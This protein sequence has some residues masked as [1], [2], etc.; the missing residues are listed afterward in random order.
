MAYILTLAIPTYN[1]ADVLDKTL[2]RIVSDPACDERVEIIVSD[3]C[4]QDSTRDVVAKYPCVKYFCNTENIIDANFTKILENSTGHYLKLVN[5]TV[6]FNPGKIEEMIDIISATNSM[7]YNLLFYQNCFVNTDKIVMV[8]NKEELLKSVS[9]YTTWSANFGI[10]KKDFDAFEDKNR[11]VETRF[12]QLDW[13]YRLVSNGKRSKI[14]FDDFFTIA[15]LKVKGGYNFYKVFVDNY[16]NLIKKN[17]ISFFAIEH[18]KYRLFRYF[19]LSNMRNFRKNKDRFAFSTEGEYR[20]LLGKYWYEP[21]FYIG[22][23][24]MCFKLYFKR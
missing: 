2:E 10:W 15:D 3:N 9:F 11:Y 5:D 1:R 24:V 21:Y 13:T 14:V 16:I 18:E 12:L 20:I 23:I 17:K 6:R 4:S 8:N 19:L 7:E 22:L